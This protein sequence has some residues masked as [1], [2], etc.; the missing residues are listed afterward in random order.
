M[1]KPSPEKWT[2][3]LLGEMHVNKVKSSDLAKELG[4]TAAYV[5]MLLNSKRN[6]KDAREKLNAA[7]Q[8]V[9][10]K[11]EQICQESQ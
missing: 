1:A 8:A 4:W 3:K 11:R 9:L 6:P 5:S 2:G 7:Y 10:A